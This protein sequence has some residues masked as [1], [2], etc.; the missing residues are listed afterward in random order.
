MGKTT[1]NKKNRKMKENNM[2]KK[3]ENRSTLEGLSPEASR[4]TRMMREKV[5]G[6]L[7]SCGRLNHL[8]SL[9]PQ[10]ISAGFQQSIVIAFHNEVL[11]YDAAVLRI[12]SEIALD[13]MRPGFIICEEHRFL[14]EAE[15]PSVLMKLS[16]PP[17]VEW[18]DQVRTGYILLMAHLFHS[19]GAAGHFRTAIALA[20]HRLMNE[21]GEAQEALDAGEITW[22]D[23][24]DDWHVEQVDIAA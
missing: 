20:M 2:K 6:E 10:E 19:E 4:K 9:H 11:S 5:W 13:D 17:L 21:A 12:L 7:T 18:P 14:D 22:E 24:H 23:L 8:M 3:L 1:R 16:N 15:F